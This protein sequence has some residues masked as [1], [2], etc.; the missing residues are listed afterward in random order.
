MENEARIMNTL[1]LPVG[2]IYGP[3]RDLIASVPGLLMFDL[4]GWVYRVS[5]SSELGSLEIDFT[6]DGIRLTPCQYRAPMLDDGFNRMTIKYAISFAERKMN[7]SHFLELVRFYFPGISFQ[8]LL[9]SSDGNG[10]YSV[11]RRWQ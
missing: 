2:Q 7:L 6:K 5:D 9:I 10:Q 1:Q 8:G 4:M 3:S 11:S